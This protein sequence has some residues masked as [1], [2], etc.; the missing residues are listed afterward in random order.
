[1]KKNYFLGFLVLVIGLVFIGCASTSAT[2]RP[3]SANETK[4]GT[5]Q[6][7]FHGN[8]DPMNGRP[9]PGNAQE[10]Y[11]LLLAEAKKLYQREDIDIRNVVVVNHSPG[12]WR[13]VA[14]T[15]TGDVI[16]VK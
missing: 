1:M 7:V 12:V 15:G 13:W 11:I 10:A 14:M 2:F 3:I 5:V 8:T 16:E 4:I 9:T 6:V